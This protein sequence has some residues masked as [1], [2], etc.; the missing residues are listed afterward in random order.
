MKPLSENEI[1]MK[2]LTIITLTLVMALMGACKT[3]KTEKAATPAIDV[4]LTDAEK[5][6]GVLT[7]EILW[8]Y[9]RLG[10]MTLSPDGSTVLYQVTN[11]DLPT[12]ARATNI[13]SV[14]PSG[15]DP[16]QLTTEGG[17][18]PQWIEGSAKIAYLAGGK[19]MVMNPDGSTKKE[20]TGLE[21]YEILS[22]SPAGD[23]VYF[24][25]RVKLDQTANEKYNLPNAK[26]R[27]IDDLMYRHWD[28]W[29]DYSYSH[30]F[31]AS[32][33]GSTIS[34]EKDIMEGQRF[35]APDAPGSTRLT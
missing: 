14:S 29:H 20:I 13:W 24:T 34:N 17:A 8:K 2:K 10:G 28:Y 3:E 11:Y 18:G 4:S 12:E 23:R 33:D 30:I 32:F 5:A 27:I 16:V 22:F 7:P 1:H 19:I 25:R 9:G 35:D 31:T 6:G 26:V 21:D 15:G